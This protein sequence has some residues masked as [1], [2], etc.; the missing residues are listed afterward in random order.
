MD[1]RFHIPKDQ[2][3]P[4]DLM[5]KVDDIMVRYCKIQGGF[6]FDVFTYDVEE[7]RDIVQAVVK[8]M[9]VDHDESQHGV[10]WETVSLIQVSNASWIGCHSFAWIYRVR[11]SY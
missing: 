1:I 10:T 7:A 6:V 3:I 9:I 4:T 8:Q 5:L 11:D 2:I